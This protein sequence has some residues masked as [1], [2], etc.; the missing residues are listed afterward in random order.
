MPVKKKIEETVEMD[1]SCISMT[2]YHYGLKR[3]KIVF[4]TKKQ[5]AVSNQLSAIYTF[6]G[7]PVEVYHQLLDSGSSGKYFNENIRDRYNCSK[8]S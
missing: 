8:E 7:I 4:K 1:S 5:S 2:C 3:L 6:F